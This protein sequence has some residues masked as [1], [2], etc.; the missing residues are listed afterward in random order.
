LWGI[1]DRAYI[2]GVLPNT[3]AD[4]VRWLRDPPG[5]DPRT[6]M[7]DMAVT[8]RAARDIA[9]YLFTLRA[10]LA[11]MRMLRG[12]VERGTGHQVPNPR[13]VLSRKPE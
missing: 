12:F 7:P 13:G 10:E 6:A 9:A 3:E 8:E 2:G 4:M 5:V 1:A 11:G